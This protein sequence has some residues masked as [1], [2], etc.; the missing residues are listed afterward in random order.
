MNGCLATNM[1]HNKNL[2][3]FG[4]FILSGQKFEIPSNSNGI[5]SIS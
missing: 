1:N 3:F 2:G 5:P 4:I